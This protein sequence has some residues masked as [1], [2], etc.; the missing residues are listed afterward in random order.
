[1]MTPDTILSFWFDE[2]KPTQWWVKDVE[3]DRVI[4]TRFLKVHQSA[5]Q[6]ELFS[7]RQSAKGRLAEI[8]ILDQ[9]SRNIFRDTPRAFASDALALILAQEAISLGAHTELNPIERNFLYMPFMHSESLLI[10]DVAVTL[11]TENGIQS[12]IDFEHQHRNIIQQFGRYPHR[13]SVLG[14]TSTETELAFLS[15]PNSSF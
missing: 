1:M 12:N 9:F 3:L 8:L 2:L 11:F 10:H 14:R 5:N 4:K 6:C 7:W 15:Q 13:N